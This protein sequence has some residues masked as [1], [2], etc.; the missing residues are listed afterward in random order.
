M[1]LETQVSIEQMGANCSGPHDGPWP[2]G[3]SANCCIQ[4]LLPVCVCVCPMEVRTLAPG[5][6]GCV[7]CVRG[8]LCV[9]RVC[10]VCVCAVMCVRA[11]GAEGNA[12]HTA[13]P[14]PQHH[15]IQHFVSF[16]SCKA[17][18]VVCSF[19]KLVGQFVASWGL[20]ISRYW[21]ELG[22]RV[23]EQCILTKLKATWFGV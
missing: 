4:N 15:Q 22:T 6:A 9:C 19:G 7:V 17:A 11:G 14:H 10:C 21:A 16:V 18:Q 2:C 3:R 23:A 5:V 1:P 12:W 20:A 8:V 13:C